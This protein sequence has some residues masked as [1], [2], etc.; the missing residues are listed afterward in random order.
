MDTDSW[1]EPRTSDNLAAFVRHIANKGEKLEEAP[2]TADESETGAPHT[3]IIAASG[4]RAAD[5]TRAL[6][7]FQSKKKNGG[8]VAKLFAKH[9]KLKEAIEECKKIK[10]VCMTLGWSLKWILMSNLQDICGCGNTTACQ[11]FA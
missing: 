5:L 9:I 1:T 6:R 7:D 11:R 8:K 4:I 10:Y 2:S 3:L